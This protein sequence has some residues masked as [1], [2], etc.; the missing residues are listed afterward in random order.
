VLT[1]RVGV[2]ALSAPRV[3]E[4]GRYPHSGWLVG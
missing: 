1:E 2:D 3:V 4:F